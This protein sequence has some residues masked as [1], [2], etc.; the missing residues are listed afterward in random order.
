[1]KHRE[2][3]SARLILLMQAIGL[4]LSFVTIF[5][6]ALYAFNGSIAIAAL[7][8]LFFVVSTFYLVTYFI[9][10]KLKRKRK[11]YPNITYAFFGVYGILSIAASFF[12][13]HFINVEFF[14]KEE[15]QNTGNEKLKGLELFYREYDNITTQFCDLS[16]TNISLA[17]NVS[18][19]GDIDP[20]T[21][22]YLKTNPLNLDD[23]QI[24]KFIEAGTNRPLQIETFKI[25]ELRNDFSNKKN[26]LLID[27]S[28]FFDR[29]KDILVHWNRL[30]I[31][32]TMSD[33]TERIVN[34]HDQ[35]SKFL[36]EKNIPSALPPQA[37]YL[38]E[39]LIN[40]P[41]DLAAKHLGVVSFAILLLFQ[42]L[43]LLPY[44]MTRGRQFG[45]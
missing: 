30:K 9:K 24:N 17:T 43:I 21:L 23:V 25:A 8:S 29:K 20:N 37:P 10:E 34:D 26:E 36:I 5:L 11:G 35:L 41:V 27:S 38:K 3:N 22:A 1:M 7:I 31:A 19:I 2:E 45:S 39:T 33:L 18:N 15:I 12:V 44:F 14:E 42:F 6:G 13:L 40:K 28:S 4:L 32:E 16:K